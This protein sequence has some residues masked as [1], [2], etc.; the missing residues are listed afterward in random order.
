[1]SVLHEANMTALR[2]TVL[3]WRPASLQA[4]IKNKQKMGL[5]LYVDLLYKPSA[6]P[7]MQPKHI[8][9]GKDH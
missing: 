8:I 5:R 1:M 9:M 3:I 4:H 6:E 2:P 7:D